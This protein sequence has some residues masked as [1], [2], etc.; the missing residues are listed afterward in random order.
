L[1]SETVK[2]SKLVVD[3]REGVLNESGDII[4]PIKEG[5]ID[6]THIYA[7]L[8]ELVAGAKKGR[9][10]DREIT[11]FKS[12]GLAIEDAITAKLAYE[13]ALKL[14]IGTHVEL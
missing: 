12:V 2:K 10:N 9:D 11:L 13:K 6:E 5:I 7:E 8:S 4:I 1:D 14:G 3:S